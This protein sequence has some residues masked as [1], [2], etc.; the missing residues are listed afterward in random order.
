MEIKDTITELQKYPALYNSV[1][2]LLS[3]KFG[4]K[5]A[6]ASLLCTY[7][8]LRYIQLILSMST[9]IS[10]WDLKDPDIIYKEDIINLFFN[11]K[12]N[13]EKKN[14]LQPQSPV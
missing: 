5:S 7:V 10:S 14:I 6:E 1:S 13:N 3:R 4:I 11:E 12:V 9:E 8:T 2:N